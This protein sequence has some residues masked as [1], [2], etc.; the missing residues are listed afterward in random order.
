MTEQELNKIRSNIELQMQCEEMA[1][2]FKTYGHYSHPLETDIA[3]YNEAISLR[4]VLGEFKEWASKK[5][6]SK[7]GENYSGRY[8]VSIPVDEILSELEKL[9][10]K[11]RY[12]KKNREE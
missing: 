12:F 5:K 1:G 8:C 4:E 11:Y 6:T 10:L 9:E 7:V 3:L 2:Y